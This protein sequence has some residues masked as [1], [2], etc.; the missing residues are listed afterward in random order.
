MR[1]GRQAAAPQGDADWA[2][3]YQALADVA[4]EEEYA[5]R[6]RAAAERREAEE[7]RRVV[8][9]CNHD[10]RAELE[11]F[12]LSAEVKLAGCARFREEGAAWFD[13]GQFTRAA[14]R[15]RK[16]I[17][18]LHYTFAEGAEE[19]RRCDAHALAAHVA[20]AVCALRQRNHRAALESARLAL[21]LEPDNVKALYVLAKALRLTAKLEQAA[22][23]L[24][25]ALRQRRAAP[26]ARVP[27]PQR[28]RVPP[29][30]AGAGAGHV[31][32][33]GAGPRPRAG[34][35]EGDDAQG[36]QA[37]LRPFR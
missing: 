9:G 1:L 6:A 8:G 3:K 33:A 21:G 14:D 31:L 16:V 24:G 11:L 30:R 17:V 34:G 18:W 26:R 29:R 20:M 25:R 4:A 2:G 35:R 28:R 32:A 27:A 7:A 36:R 12:E 19:Q 5:E 10:H 37:Q 15:F 22:E 23:A 13:E